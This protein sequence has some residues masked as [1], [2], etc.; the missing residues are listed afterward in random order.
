[1]S[2]TSFPSVICTIS[3]FTAKCKTTS[4]ELC[5]FPFQMYDNT[6]NECTWDDS[7]PED[8]RP[9]CSTEVNIEGFHIEGQWGFCGDLCSTNSTGD[10]YYAY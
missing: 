1:M 7:D 10:I 4:G 5:I 2:I 3:R 9:W 8:K 6:Y